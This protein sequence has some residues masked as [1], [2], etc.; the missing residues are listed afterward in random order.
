MD[1]DAR[2]LLI[3]FIVIGAVVGYS[4]Y[5]HAFNKPDRTFSSLPVIVKFEHNTG[6]KWQTPWTSLA[7]CQKIAASKLYENTK[8]ECLPNPNYKPP[9]K[10]ED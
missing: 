9:V 4:L 1:E 2:N 10:K 5:Q 7:G 3:F 8:V 6:T